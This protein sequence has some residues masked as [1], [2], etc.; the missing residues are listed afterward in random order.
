MTAL[1]KTTAAGSYRSQPPFLQERRWRP[2]ARKTT[3]RR[4]HLL[5]AITAGPRSIDAQRS[6]RRSEIRRG[7]RR[8]STSFVFRQHHVAGRWYLDE[9]GS[10][11][12]ISARACG[13]IRSIVAIRVVAVLTAMFT[14]AIESDRTRFND[15]QNG[16]GMR[17]PSRSASGRYDDI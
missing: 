8:F 4:V 13:L 10:G 17:M 16:T 5:R 12:I 14:R 11:R 6:T 3:W 15:Y 2:P 9:R 1:L 7:H